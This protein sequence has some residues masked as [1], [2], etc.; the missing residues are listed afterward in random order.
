MAT[1]RRP[2]HQS[3]ADKK[4][5]TRG[6]LVEAAATVFARR[7]FHGA[8][9]DEIAAEAGVT[10]GALYWHFA[11]KEDLF[12]ALADERVARRLE[13]IRR[14]NDD[15]TEPTDLD[16][17]IE[18]Q[19]QAFIE[20]EPEWPLLYYEF[21]VHGARDPRLRDAFTRRR[22]AVQGAIA[23]GL[24]QRAAKYGVDL[25]MP[26]DQIAVGLNGLMNALA[27]ERVTNPPAVP[28]G[29]AG[30]LIAAYVT[31]LIV[32]AQSGRAERA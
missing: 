22:R 15:A 32:T 21:W 5:L 4:A 1:R 16:E 30:R 14:V 26:A 19:F 7:G 27:F 18:R 12:L 9:V 3:R 20:R 24:E 6:H 13:E 11:G 29:L 28:D 25:P 17:E 31:G 10:T 23:D 8:T 2:P